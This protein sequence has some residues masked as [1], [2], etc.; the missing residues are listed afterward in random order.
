MWMPYRLTYIGVLD[1]SPSSGNQFVPVRQAAVA[2]TDDPRCAV[3][4]LA[5]FWRLGGRSS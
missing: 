3:V 2:A 4:A 5:S 1:I